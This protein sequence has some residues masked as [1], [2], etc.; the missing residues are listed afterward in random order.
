MTNEKREFFNWKL[1]KS[2]Q[3]PDLK[4][5]K[6]RFD[7]MQ[8]PRNQ[9]VEK[10]IVVE[11]NDSTNVVPVFPNGDI[12]FV[13]QYRF[14]IRK[15]TLELPGGIVDDGEEALFAAKRELREE[16]GYSAKH[17]NF[18]GKVGSNPVYMSN[19]IHHWVA[20]DIALTSSLDLDDGEVVENEVL[21]EKEVRDRLKAGKFLH[22]H[23]ISALTLYLSNK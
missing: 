1:V 11:A 7:Y 4:L 12:L 10:M 8:N 13:R 23:T 9:L 15:M 22:P 5:F 3:G 6:A 19:Y 20:T 16:S 17:W 21:S 14:G 18:L 2:E